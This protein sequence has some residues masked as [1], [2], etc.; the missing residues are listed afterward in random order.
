VSEES[1]ALLDALHPP[2]VTGQDEDV[3]FLGSNPREALAHYRIL[4]PELI[5]YRGGLFAEKRFDQT[6][7][8]DLFDQAKLGGEDAA[9]IIA[10]AEETTN[11]V[12]LLFEGEKPD[13]PVFDA[14]LARA[15]AEAIG[16][17]WKRWI[18]DTYAVEIEIVTCIEDQDACYVT[19]RS[20]PH[21][22]A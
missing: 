20:A 5:A 1:R 7:V 2:G 22:D 10:I 3:L 11:G 14:D 15:N 16:W 4:F 17:V 8:D 12:G 21:T 13:E 9:S 6:L 19:F 18:R